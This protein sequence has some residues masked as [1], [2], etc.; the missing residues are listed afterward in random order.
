[1]RYAEGEALSELINNVDIRDVRVNKIEAFVIPKSQ[2]VMRGGAY[3]AN[4]V[5]AA[6]DST[7]RPRV[8]V[9]G[10]YLPDA[11]NGMYTA[12]A[13]S[14][15]TFPV[16][17]YIEMAQGDGTF[18]KKEFS[19]EYFVQEQG[20]SI[21][22]TL[23]NALYAGIPNPVKIDVSGIVSQNINATMTNGTIV[24]KGGNIWEAT[25][26]QIGT[27]AVITITVK[28]NEGRTTEFA[29]QTYRVRRLPEP[30]VYI[31]YKDA[32]GSPVKFQKS[33]RLSRTILMNAPELKAAIDDGIL[34]IPFT[35]VSF[36]MRFYDAMK[37]SI[38]VASDGPRISARQKE[39]LR[40]L[41]RGRDF[42]ITKI[43]VKGPDGSIRDDLSPMMITVI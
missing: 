5:A 20:A 8:F 18:V 36:E 23:M 19:T 17:G 43:V 32:N 9:N 24:R 34:D 16:K 26:S 2:I 6:V 22:L 21:E 25:P 13:G 39:R 41:P 12:G 4:I 33:G 28:T 14:V 15:G 11:V 29:K 40:N 27:D 3:T 7:Q 30:T 35:V 42:N 31:E 37:N 1:V 10:K 38:P